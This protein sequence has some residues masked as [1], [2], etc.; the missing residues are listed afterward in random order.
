M[1]DIINTN[2]LRFTVRRFSPGYSERFSD[3]SCGTYRSGDHGKPRKETNM[4]LH[5]F[6]I[7][8]NVKWRPDGKAP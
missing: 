3:F 5:A 6:G 2:R 1:S 4:Y 7:V 8:A